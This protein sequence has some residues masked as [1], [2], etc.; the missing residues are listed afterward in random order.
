MFVSA[1][2]VTAARSKG[3]KELASSVIQGERFTRVDAVVDL[4]ATATNPRA[5][6]GARNLLQQ[7]AV[8]PWRVIRGAHKSGDDRTLHVTVAIA[9]TRYHLRLDGNSCVFDITRVRAGQTERPAGSKP[10]V[11]PGL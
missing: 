3:S 4:L 5:Q 10:W 11:G 9:E 1:S 6:P 2:T 7:M 8:V